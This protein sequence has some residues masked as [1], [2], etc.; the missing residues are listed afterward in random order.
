MSIPLDRLYQYIE[1]IA[2]KI[3][4]DCVLIYRFY[5]HGSKKL[6]DLSTL[7]TVPSNDWGIKLS[8][9]CN[10]QEPLNYDFYQNNYINETDFFK[11]LENHSLAEKNN[12]KKFRNIYDKVCLIHSEKRSGNLTKYQNNQFV[13]VYYWSHAILALDWFRFAE[14]VSQTKNI[15]KKFLIYNRAWAGTREYRLKFAEH[16][17]RLG[18]HNA[19]QTNIN[20]IEPE[21]DIH[22]DSHKFNNPIW[23]PHTVL[24]NFFPMSTAPSHYSA[25][26]DIKDYEATDI[27]VVLETLFDDER[28]HLTEKSLRPIAC[29]QPFILAGTHSSLEYLRS[30]SGMNAMI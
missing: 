25:D 24:E 7:I 22:Y 21:L 20:P 26:F 19:C 5:P 3:H 11:I 4:Q 14:H 27:E 10:D 8:L 23:R 13:T 15:K 9:Y 30:I 16:L 2:E 17:V 29:G 28:L 6:E 18:L 12:L 1:N